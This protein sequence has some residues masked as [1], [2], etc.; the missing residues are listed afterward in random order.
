MKTVAMQYSEQEVREMLGHAWRAGFL[1]TDE[2]F[3]A[4]Y[5]PCAGASVDADCLNAVDA[6]L[7]GRLKTKALADHFEQDGTGSSQ[8]RN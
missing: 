2:G 3:N 5:I 8:R 6:I 7:A 4:S 1:A